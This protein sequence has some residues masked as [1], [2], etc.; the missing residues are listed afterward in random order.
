MD[1][2][3]VVPNALVS[4]RAVLHDALAGVAGFEIEVSIADPAVAQFVSADVPEYGFPALFRQ[5][6]PDRVILRVLDLNDVIPIGMKEVVIVTFTIRG[7][8]PGSTRID[9]VVNTM[10][11]DRA[12]PMSP[13]VT[14]GVLL[15]P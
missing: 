13:P 4:V 3:E 8:A 12:E 5:F 14:P 15:V 1:S 6:S 11:D 10:D 9:L 2:A 7:N